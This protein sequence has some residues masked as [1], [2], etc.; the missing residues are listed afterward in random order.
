MKRFKAP[1]W[2]NAFRAFIPDTVTIL[3]ALVPRGASALV[4]FIERDVILWDGCYYVIQ[5][6]VN[7]RPNMLNT[8]HVI[9]EIYPLTKIKYFKKVS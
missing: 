7:V 2:D 9:A 5:H 1:D 3:A 6:E 8:S 4:I